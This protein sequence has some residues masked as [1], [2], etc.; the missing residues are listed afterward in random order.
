MT[1]AVTYRFYTTNY[2]RVTDAITRDPQVAR[3]TEYYRS[4]IETVK[5]VDDLLADRRLVNYVMKAYGLAEMS[6]A[7]AFIRK[8][9]TEG[10]D[11]DEA[12]AN[13]LTDRRYRDLAADFNFKRYGETTTTFERTRGGVIERYQRQSIEER[14]GETSTGAR[15]AMYF[16]RRAGDIKSA[17]DILADPA[18]AQVVRTYLGLPP[19]T[20][21]IDIDRQ[22][23]LINDRLDLAELAEPDFLARFLRDFVVRWDVENPE[24]AAV[25][26]IVPLAAGVKTISTDLLAAIQNLKAGR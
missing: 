7:T 9:L 11:S 4:K 26:S 21:M 10:V 5:S 13:Q 8:V 25:P 15:L 16:E 22:A 18:L 23:D 20:A 3:E 14:A 1:A 17:Y 24:A 2:E 6:Y 12:L 19:Q